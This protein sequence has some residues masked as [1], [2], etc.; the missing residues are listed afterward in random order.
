MRKINTVITN[1][2]IKDVIHDEINFYYPWILEIISTPEF[3]RMHKIKQLGIAYKIFPCATH[4]R[5]SHSL[6]TY[7]V[8]KRFL[9][10]LNVTCTI[11]EKNILFAAALL[12]DLG[13]GPHS[14]SFETYTNIKHEEFTKKII[15]DSRTKI[16]NI[17]LKYQIDPKQVVAIID[18]K[19]KTNYLNDIISS[20]IDA[21]RLDYLKRDSHYSGACYGR[22]DID[23]LIKW[24]L[25]ENNQIVFS[26]KAISSIENFIVGRMH[27]YK[28]VYEKPKLL[29]INSLIKKIM[30]RLKYLYVEEKKCLVDRYKIYELFSNWFLDQEWDIEDYLKINDTNFELLLEGIVYE[31]DEYLKEAIDEL[32]NFNPQNYSITP[33]DLKAYNL[34]LK[35]AKKEM[36]N[37]GI[38]IS[39]VNTNERT[40][41]SCDKKPILIYDHFV[42]RVLPI[43]KMSKLVNSLTQNSIKQVIII[44]YK[45][46]KN[47]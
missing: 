38:Y 20:Q 8:T 5:Y 34:L 1:K 15:L 23:L 33:G 16:N 21:D 12:H 39:L 41:Y 6:G 22:V 14:H 11:Q 10:N 18:G 24:A 4:T 25:I 47:I 30:D 36:K 27:M 3:L 31:N 40:V 13:H 2:F 37:P 45:K 9:D 35:K 42:N 46:V 44:N 17:L 29:M 7:E 32:N 43:H 26:D 28:E 19:H